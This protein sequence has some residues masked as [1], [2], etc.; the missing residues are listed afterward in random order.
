MG[1]TKLRLYKV[2]VS[3]CQQTHTKKCG[4]RV[5]T[6]SPSPGRTLTRKQSSSNWQRAVTVC[7]RNGSS[8]LPKFDAVHAAL[9]C[10][11]CAILVFSCP[12]AIFCF[13][14]KGRFDAWKL[15]ESVKKLQIRN[16][17]F[18]SILHFLCPENVTVY[19]GWFPKK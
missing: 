11:V 19:V 16:L 4:H 8:Y 18:Y 13:T 3:S 15:R 2:G 6:H 1:C 14:R 9:Y 5:C 12:D 10:W 17:F 7:E